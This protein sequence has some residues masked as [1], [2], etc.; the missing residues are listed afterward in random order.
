MNYLNEAI[1]LENNLLNLIKEEKYDE[2]NE[3]LKE[4]EVFYKSFAENNPKEMKNF[5]ISKDFNNI[6]EQI[7]KEYEKQKEEIKKQIRE[8]A[9]S[10]KATEEYRNNS[11]NIRSFF[12]KKV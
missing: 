1:N 2:F 5:L 3:Q 9:N 8:L 10:K 4:R 11:H 7:N 6:R 12:S